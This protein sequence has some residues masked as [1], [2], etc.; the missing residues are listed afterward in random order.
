MQI[1]NVHRFVCSVGLSIHCLT[2][3]FPKCDLI[4]EFRRQVD[5][6]SVLKGSRYWFIPAAVRNMDGTEYWIV[7]GKVEID[8]FSDPANSNPE[9]LMQRSGGVHVSTGHKGTVVRWAMFASNWASL[10][11]VA[12]T[13][14]NMPGPYT[15]EFF[16]S[17][18]FT[19][20]VSDPSEAYLRLNDLIVK[21]DI[22]LRQKTFV[23]SMDPALSSWVPDLL[24]DVYNERASRPD[25]TVDCVLDTETDRFLVDRVGEN[26]GIAKLFGVQPDT[27]PCLSGHSYDHIVS[28]AYKQVLRT[29]EPHYDHVIASIP[30]NKT[31]RWFT[32]QR[33]ILPHN[34]ADGRQGVS[35]VSEFGHV[36][37]NLL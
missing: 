32:Y 36:D 6:V 27:F 25:V 23:K 24:T 19:Q 9:S 37:I 15:F 8:P 14:R 17:G 7:N 18:W 2:F 29:G 34:F 16:L 33:V 10:Y 12:E 35:I 1:E 22:H 11:Y 26:S 5:L 3:Y 4:M 30:M 13:L 31:A 28:S 21:S 20:T